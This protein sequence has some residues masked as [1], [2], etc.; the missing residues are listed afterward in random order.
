MTEHSFEDFTAV[1]QSLNKVTDK[2]TLIEREKAAAAADRKHEILDNCIQEEQAVL[3]KLRGLEQK[4]SRLM[5]GLGWKDLTFRQL[6]ERISPEQREILSPL[7]DELNGKLKALTSAKE[8]ADR[9]ILTRVR[10]LEI[11]LSR[12]ENPS[13]GSDGT[14]EAPRPFSQKDTYV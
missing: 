2:I 10:E 3:L 12:R 7:F 13:Y 5:E 4:R 6:L 9:M 8:D 11:F 1:I 14:S